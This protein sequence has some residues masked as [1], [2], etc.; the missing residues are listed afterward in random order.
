MPKDLSLVWDGT[1]Q[2]CVLRFS[3]ETNDLEMTESL[4]PSVLVSLF[5]DARAANDDP[6]PDIGNPDRR[7]WWGDDTNTAKQGDSVGS[8]LWLLEREKSADSVL[9]KAKIYIEEALQWM[10]DEGIAAKVDVTTESQPVERSGTVILAYQIQINKPTGVTE[11]F[12][13]EQEWRATTNGVQ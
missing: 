2:G 3:T 11:T 1:Q 5:T 9:V 7:G 10:L 4:L 6:L 8:K 12:K 13:F